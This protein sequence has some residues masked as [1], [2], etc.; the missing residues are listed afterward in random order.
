MAAKKKL[1]FFKNHEDQETK[2]L[3]YGDQQPACKKLAKKDTTYTDA[4]FSGDWTP[5]ED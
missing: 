1:K 3:K 5:D 2:D 4:S